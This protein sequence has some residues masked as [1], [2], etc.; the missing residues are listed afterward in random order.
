[1]LTCPNVMAASE[2]LAIE[3]KRLGRRFGRQWA[4][5]HLDLA[6][7]NGDSLLIAGPNGCGKTTLLQLI[8]GILKPTTG[9]LEVL[10]HDPRRARMACRRRLS[11]VSHNSFLYD[12]LTAKES[13]RLWAKI[14]RN[15]ADDSR[16]A[17]LLEE[18]GLGARGNSVVSAFSAGMRK[19]LSLA[20]SRLEE[21]DLLLLDEPFAALDVDGQALIEN[22]IRQSRAKGVTVVVA[23]H[24]IERAA[25]LCRRA[26]LLTSGQPLWN[27]EAADLPAVIES[28]Q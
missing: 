19:R 25:S 8:A 12:Q 4:L 6:V 17:S 14:L 20:R 24:Q 23:S 27:G 2:G 9:S 28:S 7:A 21:P 13:M 22:W 18:A 26:V 5:A 16:L 15:G 11:L 3:A 1:M 10:G